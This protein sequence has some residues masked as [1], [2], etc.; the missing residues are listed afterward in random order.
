MLKETI[1]YKSYSIEVHYDQDPTSPR[2]CNLG[3]IICFHRR[4]SLSDDNLSFSKSAEDYNSWAEMETAIKNHYKTDIILPIYMYDHSG[5]T[6]STS[7]FSCRWD[8]GQVGWIIV[9]RKGMKECMGWSK[10]TEQ[11]EEQLINILKQE[12]QTYDQYL[13]GDV[14]G[15]EIYDEEGEFVD[16]CWG[17]YGREYCEKEAE[18]IVAHYEEKSNNLTLQQ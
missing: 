9:D 8:S 3:N 7:P 2:D 14:W 16:S 11:R 13:T 18:Y 4:Y 5:I 15:Y 12:V 1:Q 17:F 10:I 6:I